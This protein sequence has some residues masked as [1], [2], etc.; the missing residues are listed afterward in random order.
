MTGRTGGDGNA[1]FF[2]SKR[3][4]SWLPEME[5]PL[6]LSFEKKREVEGSLSQ[7]KE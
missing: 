5:G 2:A 7:V 4:N 6:H 3:P 1:L